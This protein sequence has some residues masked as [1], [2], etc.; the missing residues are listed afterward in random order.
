MVFST[1]PTFR[2]VTLT[3]EK[4]EEVAGFCQVRVTV[5]F[6]AMPA[7]E[8]IGG[9][10]VESMIPP[11][12]P[13]RGGGGGGGGRGWRVWWWRFCPFGNFIG[14]ETGNVHGKSAVCVRKILADVRATDCSVFEDLGSGNCYVV[15]GQS[16]WDI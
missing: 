3:R 6:R 14:G 13:P 2:R 5:W 16:G 9:G 8:K 11:P 7:R 10:G 15:E 1:E 4:S 12:P